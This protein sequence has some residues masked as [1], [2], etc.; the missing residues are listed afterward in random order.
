[1]FLLCDIVISGPVPMVTPSAKDGRGQR[2][3]SQGLTWAAATGRA[4]SDTRH[5]PRQQAVCLSESR[6][7]PS[8]FTSHEFLDAAGQWPRLRGPGLWR[9]SAAPHSAL[10]RSHL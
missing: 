9:S 7:D 3:L 4:R 1:M 5:W 2:S 8:S 10:R 6:G